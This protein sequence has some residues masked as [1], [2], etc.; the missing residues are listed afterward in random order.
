MTVTLGP[1][2]LPAQLL[3][4]FAT[5]ILGSAIGNRVAARSGVKAEGSLWLIIAGAIL[6]AR[7]VFV[8]RYW[9]LYAEEPWRLPDLR[10]GGLAPIAGFAAAIVIGA[11]L[12]WRRAEQ[13]AAI[14]TALCA[15]I[16]IWIGGSGLIHAT[17]GRHALPEV[18]LTDLD[19]R[20]VPLSAFAGKPMVVNLW[21]SWCPP[22][23]R[24]MPALGKAQREA[25]DLTFVFVNQGE[26][27][28]KV[29]AYLKAEGLPLR[30]VVLDPGGALAK[31]AG[32]PGLPTTL[33]VDADGILVDKRMG[34]VS[35]ATLAEHLAVLRSKR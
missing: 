12:A 27:S 9:P 26:D 11:I 3:V 17:T 28:A 8:A 22:C 31:A 21:A 25:S 7:I 6:V 5:I 15:G 32:A 2:A 10:D 30:N 33:F 4:T 16:F 20:A 14:L 34:E 19:G 18:M 29:R 1:L 24:E 23:R 13:R 35:S